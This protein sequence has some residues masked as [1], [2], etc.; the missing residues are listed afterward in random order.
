MRASRLGPEWALAAILSLAVAAAIAFSATPLLRGPAPYPPE[1]QWDARA[2]VPREGWLAVTVAGAALLALAGLPERV[3]AR[4]GVPGVVIAA[5]VVAGC[6]FALA[7]VGLEP[8]GAAA[9]LMERATSR[10]ATSYLNVAESELARDPAAFVDRHAELLPELRKTAKHAATHPLGPVLYYR[11]LIAL[12]ERAPG[13]AAALLRAAGVDPGAGR[14]SLAVRAAAL[15]GPLLILL[16]CAAAGWPA[17]ALARAAGADREAAA[18]LAALW[19]LVP[20][21]ALMSPHFDQVL[22]LPVTACA[23][24]AAGAAEDG[25]TARGLA[26]GLCAGF[27]LQLSYG[28]AAFLAIVSLAALAAVAVD[29]S[30]KAAVLVAAGSAALAMTL[31]PMAWGHD[32]WGAARAALAIHREVYTAPRSYALWLLFNPLDLALFAGVPVV[33]LGMA[34]LA[35]GGAGIGAFDRMARALAIGIALLVLS[36]AVRGEVGRIAI[37]LMPVMLV[38]ALGGAGDGGDRPTAAEALLAGGL[39]LVLTLVIAARWAV[40]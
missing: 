5:S 28:A 24:L 15:M 22:A 31:L 16:A 27:A 39:L 34:R 8:K 23:A 3:L 11:A 29:A 33:V 25:S 17:A 35:R 32:P 26:A 2:V 36:G 40:A 20:G 37:P 38:A 7:L 10:T 13:A 19:P 14:R 21:A 18:R 12:F 6:A 9:T 1:W 30:R 4:A